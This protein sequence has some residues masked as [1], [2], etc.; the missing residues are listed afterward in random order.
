LIGVPSD[1]VGRD[2]QQREEFPMV[3][4][5][6]PVRLRHFQSDNVALC[7]AAQ[8]LRALFVEDITQP[9]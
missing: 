2:G 1:R 7:H 8:S 5:G 6:A 9:A 4:E 3:R